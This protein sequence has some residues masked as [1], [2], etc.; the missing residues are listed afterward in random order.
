MPPLS[1]F[2]APNTPFP[3]SS[4]PPLTPTALLKTWWV[5]TSTLPMWKS[6][7]NIRITYT[8]IPSTKNIDDI[9]H[10]N[11]RNG[12][13]ATNSTPEEAAKLVTKSIHGVDYPLSENEGD[14]T[15]KWRGKGLLFI[16]TSRWQVVGYG[17][18]D[19]RIV[20]GE[21]GEE[22]L[23]GVEWV[24]TYF[25]KSLFTPAGVDVMTVAR[26]G[27]DG[28]TLGVIGEGLKGIG[29]VLGELWGGIFDIPR[30]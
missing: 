27:V 12:P 1:I 22:V 4:L 24:V 20:V 3:S 8:S 26:E 17:G 10:Y 15:Y 14:L 5:T 18:R 9:I 19:V 23:E 13:P 30:D 21:G 16:A 7:K 25:E 6:A 29:G 2:R 28:E 11:P